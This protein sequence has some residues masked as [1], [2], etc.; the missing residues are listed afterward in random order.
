MKV[1]TGKQVQ[2]ALDLWKKVVLPLT[3]VL[4][5]VTDNKKEELIKLDREV[6]EGKKIVSLRS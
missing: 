4:D 3:L 1:I 6:K 2:E 5:A